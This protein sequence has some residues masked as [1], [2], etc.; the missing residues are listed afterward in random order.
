MATSREEFIAL[1][2][3]GGFPQKAEANIARV[4]RCLQ[5]VMAAL[6]PVLATIHET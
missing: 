1:I 5:E 2:S 6:P 3:R 4:H